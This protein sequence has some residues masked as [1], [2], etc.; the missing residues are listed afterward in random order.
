M[1]TLTKIYVACNIDKLISAIVCH[2]P[3]NVIVSEAR[4][5]VAHIITRTHSEF[6]Q[7]NKPTVQAF[8]AVV[9]PDQVYLAAAKVGCKS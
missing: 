7:T 6:D 4:Q 2:L 9:K 5:S 8:F 3:K 1:S